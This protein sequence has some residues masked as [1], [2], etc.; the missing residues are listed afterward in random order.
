M[1]HM[2]GIS[3]PRGGDADAPRGGPPM[4]HAAPR[5]LFLHIGETKA[6]STSL[7]NWLEG[8]H[9]WLLERGQLFPR[10]GFGRGN[11]S[12]PSRSAGHLHL[13]HLLRDG[14]LAE[15]EAELAAAPDADLILS[16]EN[17]FLDQPDAALSSL[18]EYF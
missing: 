5:R 16:S 12:D 10:A 15:F 4:T 6:G 3:G 7:Q 17:L 11:A 2:P 9:D 13:L 1:D 18:G 8:R 14:S